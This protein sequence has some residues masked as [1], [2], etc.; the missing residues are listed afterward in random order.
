MLVAM[1]K[2]NNASTANQ[3][4]IFS[5]YISDRLGV[6]ELWQHKQPLPWASSSGISLFTAAIPCSQSIANFARSRFHQHYTLSPLQDLEFRMVGC[7]H[8]KTFNPCPT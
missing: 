1:A 8:M 6:K 2:V 4:S 5:K 7:M 3:T